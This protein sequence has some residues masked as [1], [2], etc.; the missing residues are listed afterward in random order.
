MPGSESLQVFV[1][2]RPPS[3]VELKRSEE[4]V[5]TVE[6]SNHGG[7]AVLQLATGKSSIR[8]KYDHVADIPASQADVFVSNDR[9]EEC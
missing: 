2:V 3:L 9:R 6:T 8:C 7:K 4:N 1:R 5:V